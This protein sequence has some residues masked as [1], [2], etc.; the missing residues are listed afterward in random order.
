MGLTD[1]RC[2][3]PQAGQSPLSAEQ[4]ECLSG[5]VSPDWELEGEAIS[6]TVVFPG[7]DEA[8][9]FVNAVAGLARAEDHHPDLH[10]SYSRVQVTLSTHK[11]G[12]LSRND[13]IVAAKIDQLLRPGPGS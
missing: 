8:M 2:A 7:F 10:V 3:A 13:F 5:Q 4:A 1:E 9:G 11:I 6:R 12:G